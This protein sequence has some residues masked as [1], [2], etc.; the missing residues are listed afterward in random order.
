MTNFEF[1]LS[2]FLVFHFWIIKKYLLSIE[3][4]IDRLLKIYKEDE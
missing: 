3:S 1:A 2:L 4:K